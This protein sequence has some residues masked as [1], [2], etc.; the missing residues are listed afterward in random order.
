[1]P[2]KSMK[3]FKYLAEPKKHELLEKPE[4]TLTDVMYRYKASQRLIS[5]SRPVKFDET[6]FIRPVPEPIPE[7]VL[8]A[9]GEYC[10]INEISI[11]LWRKIAIFIIRIMTNAL[12]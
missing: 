11:T 2:L 3:R 4:W 10:K 7:S 1:M 12:I 6:K 5:L 9:V 8:K